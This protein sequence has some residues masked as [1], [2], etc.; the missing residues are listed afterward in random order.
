MERRAASVEPRAAKGEER[1]RIRAMAE[2][3]LDRVTAIERDTFGRE[4]WPR[5]AFAELGRIFARAETIRG[6]FWVAEASGTAEIVGYAGVELSSLFGEADLINIAVAPAAKRRGVGRALI[7]RAV[8]LCRRH[9]VPLLWLRVRASNTSARQFYVRLGFTERGQFAGY[10][11]DPDEP[12]V[13]MAMD[14]E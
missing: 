5:I 14:L 10:Y 6:A 12:A 13:I 3:D 11:V 7:R 4:A 9:G 8:Q 2:A 1:I